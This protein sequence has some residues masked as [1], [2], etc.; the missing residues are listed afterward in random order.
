DRIRTEDVEEARRLHLEEHAPSSANH[1]MRILKLLYRWATNRELIPAVPWRL[2]MFRVQKRP[3]VILPVAKASEWLAAV[4]ATA[5]ARWGLAT[6]VRLGLGLG[7]RESEQLSARWE[8]I[9][10][11]RSTYTPGITKGR[12]AVPLPL[13]GWLREH[14]ERRRVPEGLIVV[15]PSGGR[16]CAG[17]TRDLVAKASRSIGMAGLTPHRLRGGFASMLAEEGMSVPDIQD[18][19]RHKDART[20]MGYIE[21][22]LDRAVGALDRIAHR[23]GMGRENGEAGRADARL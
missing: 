11:E 13:R 2:G 19:M 23:M 1:W 22:N 3:R 14:L 4:D 12:E 18:L 9:D 15:S 10:W 6:A 7:L 16:Y 8:W 20:T 21:R 17:A 5:G